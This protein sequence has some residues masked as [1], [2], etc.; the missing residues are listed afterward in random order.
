MICGIFFI[1]SE[2][3]VVIQCF[4]LFVIKTVCPLY[5]YYKLLFYLDFNIIL[6]TT[7]PNLSPTESW[8][9]MELTYCGLMALDYVFGKC[10]VENM[11]YENRSYLP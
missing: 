1:L 9:S 10:F 8:N 5:N 3:N 7:P 2:F 4:I 6:T 11:Y